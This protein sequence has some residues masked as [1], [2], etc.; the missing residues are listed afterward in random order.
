MR[1]YRFK[2]NKK[3]EK[4]ALYEITNL[5]QLYLKNS[6]IVNK[7]IRQ[8]SSLNLSLKGLRFTENFSFCLCSGRVRYVN[9]KLMLSRHYFSEYLGK[10]NLFGYYM[11]NK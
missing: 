2:F 11:F 4:F 3:Y 7:I 5:S 8:K 10:G 6:E 9:N 1:K